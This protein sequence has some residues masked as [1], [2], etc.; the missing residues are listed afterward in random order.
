MDNTSLFYNFASKRK[1]L[2]DLVEK[3]LIP[4]DK[5]SDYVLENLT[6]KSEIHKMATFNSPDN[7]YHITDKVDLQHNEMIMFTCFGVTQCHDYN[8]QNTKR[9]LNNQTLPNLI[10]EVMKDYSYDTLHTKLDDDLYRIGVHA[11]DPSTNRGYSFIPGIVDCIIVS[12]CKFIKNKRITREGIKLIKQKF[13]AIATMMQ[14]Y[15]YQ[16]IICALPGTEILNFMMDKPDKKFVYELAK[17]FITIIKSYKGV[18][19][20]FID[21]QKHFEYTQIFTKLLFQ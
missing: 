4:S 9:I 7:Q 10:E 5:K 17:T 18:N 1:E 19:F 3:S 21:N 11:R 6:S 20:C 15:N 12:E 13:N 8:Y 14:K 2:N 16:K